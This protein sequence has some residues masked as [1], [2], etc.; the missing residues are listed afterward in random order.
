MADEPE[1]ARKPR[2]CPLCGKP[3]DP[4]Y[5]PFCSALC[6]DRD[7]LAWLEERYAVPALADEAAASKPAEAS[8]ERREKED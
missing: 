7:L 4:R 3:T 2:L 5:R 8:R 1:R 6:R